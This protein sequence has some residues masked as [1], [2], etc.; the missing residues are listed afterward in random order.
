VTSFEGGEIHVRLA[1][2][3]IASQ[4]EEDLRHGVQEYLQVLEVEP[5]SIAWFSGIRKDDIIVA[6]NQRRTANREQA[7][8]AAGRSRS[9][10]LTLQRGDRMLQLM[11]Q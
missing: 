5:D 11:L 3:R 2:A 4:R 7:E 1:G 8:A 6:I 9:L 10:L